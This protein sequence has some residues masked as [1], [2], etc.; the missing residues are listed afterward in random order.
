MS[1]T[2]RDEAM[3][4]TRRDE[5]MSAIAASSHPSNDLGM[6]SPDLLR[7]SDS[8][9]NMENKTD[10][11]LGVKQFDGV[12]SEEITA[13]MKTLSHVSV[14]GIG[15]YID[16][17][18]S[19]EVLLELARLKANSI[20]ILYDNWRLTSS[21]SQTSILPPI[22][23]SRLP[24]IFI[25]S[26]DGA[27]F[28]SPMLKKSFYVMKNKDMSSPT[29]V[30]S[31]EGW[32][33]FLSVTDRLYRF[34]EVS[35]VNPFSGE[36]LTLPPGPHTAH[37][38]VPKAA[39]TIR[40]GRPD[41]VM[42]PCLNGSVIRILLARPGDEKWEEHPTRLIAKHIGLWDCLLCA[43]SVYCF[44][45]R[46]TRLMLFHLDRKC[47]S[48]YGD[49]E[50]GPYLL[51]FEG[52]LLSVDP[53]LSYVSDGDKG[54]MVRELI[55]RQG[56]ASVVKLND[57][58]LSNKSWFL[59]P[60]QSFCARMMG[61]KVFQ[62]RVAPQTEREVTEATYCVY[63]HDLLKKK[64]RVLT[65]DAF[66]PGYRWVDLGGVMVTRYPRT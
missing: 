59:G 61:Q 60:Y 48:A 63:Y 7:K 31:R 52:R 40:D 39:F 51:E 16:W 4:A 23:R 33:M 53:P 58:D 10:S 11:E 9:R 29:L 24:C 37:T 13:R 62:F 64:F 5:A 30:Y 14:N 65:P 50:L 54:F 3:S 1:A 34:C 8:S 28:G 45:D 2:R 38:P 44:F 27:F 57:N 12:G 41:L 47:W 17:T 36:I 42:F 19:K 22:P 56:K 49:I 35:L 15:L 66:G 32:L 43:R 20:V 25:P 26:G 18:E 6:F 21:D 46:G 55:I